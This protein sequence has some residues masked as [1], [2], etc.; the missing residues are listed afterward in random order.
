MTLLT[1]TTSFSWVGLPLACR[2]LCLSIAMA[3]LFSAY[4]PPLLAAEGDHFV[5]DPTATKYAVI[6]VGAAASQDRASEFSRW[7]LSLRRSLQEDYGYAPENL[8]TLVGAG[9]GSDIDGPCREDSIRDT[10]KS[11]AARIEPGDQFNVF[12]IGHGTGSGEGA[13]FNIVGPDLTGTEFEEI[14][15]TINTQ[16]I[17]VVNTTS[18]SYGFSQPLSANGRIIVSATRSSAE[19]YDTVFPRYFVEALQDHAADRDKNRRVSILEAFV[20]TKAR[21]D[22]YFNERGTL[23]SEHATVDDSGDGVFSVD[24]DQRGDGRLAEIAYLDVTS[25]AA[26]NLS[27][28]AAQLRSQMGNLERDIFLLRANKSSLAESEYWAQL[29]PLLI[30][31]AKVTREFDGLPTP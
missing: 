11:L 9:N 23:P 4:C 14:L 17:I 10:F 16:N 2:R 12:L 27:P 6:L 21:V 8:R 29:E 18:A 5:D 7:A 24:P 28:A 31:L 15:S 20:Y 22:N 13:K 30:E 25:A 19:K 26:T 1:P 3:V